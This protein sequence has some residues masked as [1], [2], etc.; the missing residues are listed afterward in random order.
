MLEPGAVKVARRVL[1]GL[2][3]GNT[4][5]LPDTAGAS[6]RKLTTAPAAG[7]LYVI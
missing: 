2:G 5:R 1:R 7:E 6:V 4:P 3:S